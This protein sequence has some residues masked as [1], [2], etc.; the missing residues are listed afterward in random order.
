LPEAQVK[1]QLLPEQ[2]AV[3]PAGVAAQ[4]LV[5]QRVFEQAMSQPE[6]VHT[7][8]PLDAGG[9]HLVPQAKQFDVSVARLTQAVP[10][11]VLVPQSTTHAPF[12]QS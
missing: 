4:Q 7:A 11:R 12:S 3:A 2:P 8:L 6:A 10:Q 1:V 5:P 9:L